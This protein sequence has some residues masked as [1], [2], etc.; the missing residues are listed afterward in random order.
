MKL[1]HALTSTFQRRIEE[2]TT[3]KSFVEVR[4]REVTGVQSVV[5]LELRCSKRW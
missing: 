3:S 2:G 5:N 4:D 1:L